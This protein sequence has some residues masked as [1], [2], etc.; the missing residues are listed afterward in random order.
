MS[1]LESSLL[2]L[3]DGL[4]GLPHS[5]RTLLPVDHNLEALKV[6]QIGARLP[7]SELLREGG[8]GPLL[9]DISLLA[10]LHEGAGASA[11]SDRE[12]HPGQGQSFQW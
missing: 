2:L 6:G 11:T 1:D 3:G 5:S 10:G 8:S 7:L 12:L 9:G 4:D